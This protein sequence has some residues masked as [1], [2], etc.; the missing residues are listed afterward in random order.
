MDEP[1][2]PEYTVVE[3]DGRLVVEKVGETRKASFTDFRPPKLPPLEFDWIR[4]GQTVF[5]R[6]LSFDL[7]EDGHAVITVSQLEDSIK[8]SA[9]PYDLY[10]LTPRQQAIIG[11]ITMLHRW[12]ILMLLPTLLVFTFIFDASPFWLM[13]M[14][15]MAALPLTTYFKDEYEAIR[16]QIYEP[17]APQADA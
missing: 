2:Q 9:R 3:R 10:Y 4:L 5:A 1:P 6:L 7:T 13:L 11:F 8:L 15:A 14:M 17:P 16:Q 12:G